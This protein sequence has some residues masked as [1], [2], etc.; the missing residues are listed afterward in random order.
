MLLHLFYSVVWFWFYL[1]WIWKFILNDFGN[2]FKWEKKRK[3]EETLPVAQRPRGPPAPN[4]AGLLSLFSLGL[5]SRA[6]AFLRSAV[7]VAWAG[8]GC[9][10]RARA[11]LWSHWRV[12]PDGQ[13]RLPSS[14]RIRAGDE[15]VPN[16]IHPSKLGFPSI[17]VTFWG[18]KGIPAFPLFSFPTITSSRTPSIRA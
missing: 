14:R 9:R 15:F 12:V 10:S 2:K 6:A 17:I 7:A 3:K 18:Y 11:S 4:R 16:R 5:P 13:P 1:I 8:P